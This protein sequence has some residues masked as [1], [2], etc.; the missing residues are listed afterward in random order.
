MRDPLPEDLN[1]YP[2][3]L[4]NPA[5]WVDPEGTIS[6]GAVAC[7]VCGGIIDLK[8][9]GIIV[10]CIVGCRRAISHRIDCIKDCLKEEL[11]ELLDIPESIK[12]FLKCLKKDPVKAG[13]CFA[14]AA[15]LLAKF[16]EI[17]IKPVKPSPKPIVVPMPPRP[18]KVRKPGKC[19]NYQ[20]MVL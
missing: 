6:I 7:I 2:Y 11:G 15:W 17:L 16:G 19:F 20:G 8:G 1:F 3:T 10:G 12:E 4:N 14:C 13:P 18:P 9:I 5:S